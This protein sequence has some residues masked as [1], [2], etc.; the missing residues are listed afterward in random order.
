MFLAH[1]IATA[2]HAPQTRERRRAEPE[3]AN[4]AY[5]TATARNAA[6]GRLLRG[7]V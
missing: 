3:A 4:A 5:A 6:A 1:L 7:S 2:Q